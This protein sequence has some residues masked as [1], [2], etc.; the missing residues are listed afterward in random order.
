M[1]RSLLL[2]VFALS[3]RE[4]GWNSQAGAVREPPLLYRIPP[5][6]GPVNPTKHKCAPQSP[7]GCHVCRSWEP[8]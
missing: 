6:T 2:K 3:V 8:A 4:T 7:H 5:S 1:M